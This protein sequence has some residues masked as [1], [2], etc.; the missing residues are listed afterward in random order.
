MRGAGLSSFTVL[1]AGI[2]GVCSALALQ[3]EGH[4]VTLVDRDEPG[5]G[6]SF[7]NAGILHAGGVLPLG[8][9]GIL[10]K[11][12]GMLLN[13]E[14]A[15]VIRPLKKLSRRDRGRKFAVAAKTPG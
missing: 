4:S 3:R 2:V 1:G 14:G 13:R 11:V 15:L 12:P 6:C 9:P 10:A 5:R 7:G 8:R